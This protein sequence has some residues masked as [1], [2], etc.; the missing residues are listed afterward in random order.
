[1]CS[2][3]PWLNWVPFTQTGCL[4]KHVL[5]LIAL[6]IVASSVAA[7]VHT[8]AQ[9]Q[10]QQSVYLPAVFSRTAAVSP[11]GVQSHN[12]ADDRLLTA[13]DEVGIGAVR[14]GFLSWRSV[15]PT[16]NGP[17]NWDGAA[18]IEVVIRRLHA[19]GI[20]PLI[21]VGDSPAWAT[22]PRA[23]DGASTS[24]G[25]IR[26]EAHD[27][28]ARFMRAAVA[29]YAAEPF[30]V[31]YWE[32]GNE[33]DIDS[34]I[35]NP[36]NGFGCW[37]DIRDPYY[38]GERYGRMLKV[39]YPA[40]KQANPEAE[41]LF[42]G[43]LLDNPNSSPE[44]GKPERFLEGALRAGAGNA[45]DVLPYHSYPTYLDQGRIG[46]IDYDTATPGNPWNSLGG[47][48]RGKARFL[49]EVL[50]R[51]GVDK[52]VWLNE[53][54]LM[55]P[56]ER[57]NGFYRWC[58]PPNAA[59]YEAQADYLVRAYARALSIGIEH[60]TWYSLENVWRQTGLV[61]E[62][63]NKKLSFLAYNQLIRQLGSAYYLGPTSYGPDVE[64]YRFNSGTSH[65]HVVWAP[66][67]TRS[68]TIVPDGDLIGVYTRNGELVAPT[69]Q[70][71]YSVG[72]SPI[73]LVFNAP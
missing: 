11:W 28:F 62:Q 54:S 6:F 42:G 48:V 29:R 46:Q 33:I 25:P 27:D 43:L 68:A 32:L 64:G 24:C 55:C 31:R 44:K 41:V 38:G 69:P 26:D 18:D 19:R 22:V 7:P 66:V 12:L 61:D 65:V 70:G 20:E 2:S 8:P 57:V 17:Y 30:G 73:Y 63:Q 49:R 1:M 3:L 34:S 16:A 35:I 45:F 13:A 21:I 56:E 50:A 9:A 10:S 47:G 71:G 36:D 60:V 52:R 37:G 53:T 4:V 14:Y 5:P 23:V 58:N 39:V 15:Q 72:F 67:A 59:F 40:I 51:Y